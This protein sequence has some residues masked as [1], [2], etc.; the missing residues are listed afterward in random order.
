MSITVVAKTKVGFDEG[1]IFISK[2][3][4]SKETM[5]DSLFDIESISIHTGI[6]DFARHH[7]F[8]FYG[9]SNDESAK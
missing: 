3:L 4:A 6:K 2:E 5:Q 1:N 8:Y 7:D 9:T